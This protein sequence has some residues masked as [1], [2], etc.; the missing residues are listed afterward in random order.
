MQDPPALLRRAAARLL[1]SRRLRTSQF[2]HERRHPVGR[3]FL[4][5]EAWGVDADMPSLAWP[6]SVDTASLV[7]AAGNSTGIAWMWVACRSCALPA[8]HQDSQRVPFG[9]LGN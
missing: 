9:F 8:P 4:D 3:K 6:T 5:M 7:A 1:R 2:G